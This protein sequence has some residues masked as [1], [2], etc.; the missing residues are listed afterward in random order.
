MAFVVRVLAWMSLQ[1]FDRLE[2]GKVPVYKKIFIYMQ[3]HS[4]KFLLPVLGPV[5]T[6]AS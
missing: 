2:R 3:K 4:P 6:D 1:T 5:Q